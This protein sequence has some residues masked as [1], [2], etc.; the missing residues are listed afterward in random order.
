MENDFIEFD[1]IV[2]GALGAWN[3]LLLRLKSDSL[4]RKLKRLAVSES[5]GML[6]VSRSLGIV[7]A[8]ERSRDG[9]VSAVDVFRTV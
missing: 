3:A 7:P 9:L 8:T 2:E 6:P 4:V 5:F 1:F